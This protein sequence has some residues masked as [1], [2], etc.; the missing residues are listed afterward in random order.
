LD[1][2]QR[3]PHLFFTETGLTE[4]RAMMT[5][6]RFTDPAKFAHVRQEL[7]VDPAPAVTDSQV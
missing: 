7:G 2:I 5:D 4:L 1:T 6:R 3:L